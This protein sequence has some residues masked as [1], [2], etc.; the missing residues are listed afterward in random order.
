MKI[1][2]IFDQECCTTGGALNPSIDD[3]LMASFCAPISLFAAILPF[4]IIT[5][6]SGPSDIKAVRGTSVPGFLLVT[7]FPFYKL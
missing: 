4:I 7:P 1:S 6:Y 5:A 2:W 3:L